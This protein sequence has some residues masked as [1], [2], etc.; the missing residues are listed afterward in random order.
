MQ[1]L[2]PEARAIRQHLSK[3]EPYSSGCCCVG[4]LPLRRQSP[5]ALCDW[6]DEERNE[7]QLLVND[8]GPQKLKVLSLIRAE[9]NITAKQAIALPSGIEL[10]AP[11]IDES[12]VAKLRELGADVAIARYSDRE[13]LCACAMKWVELV[14]NVYYHVHTHRSA[15]GITH[16][17]ERI[18]PKGGPY[19]IRQA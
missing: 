3:P 8:L 10:F 16:T 11:W 19:I 12:F 17:A 14:D 15:D 13:P 4:C 2:T 6:Y 9:F 7:A 18:G 1:D 5:G